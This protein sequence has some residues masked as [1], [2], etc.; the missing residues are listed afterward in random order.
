MSSQ[1]CIVGNSPSNDID[2]D[3][4][5]INLDRNSIFK[6]ELLGVLKEGFNKFH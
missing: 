4:N 2:L 1:N 6:Q 5:V 3:G